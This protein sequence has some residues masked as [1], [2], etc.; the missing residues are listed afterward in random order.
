MCVQLP[1]W[2][3]CVAMCRKMHGV[4]ANSCSI[5]LLKTLLINNPSSIHCSL[6]FW[7]L[8]YVTVILRST[9][10]FRLDP[11]CVCGVVR[12]RWYECVCPCWRLRFQIDQHGCG[13]STQTDRL[14][15]GRV[16]PS[17]ALCCGQEDDKR[18]VRAAT[19]LREGD[20]RVCGRWEK[21][22]WELLTPTSCQSG[23][24]VQEA[25]STCFSS[26]CVFVLTDI[27]GNKVLENIATQDQKEQIKAYR[28]KLAVIKEVLARRHMKVAF[29]GRLVYLLTRFIFI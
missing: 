21:F 28:D 8:S 3:P 26:C 19:P 14:G 9:E 6:I 4:I 15:P 13:A 27:S 17:Q 29:F 11:N 12:A 23:V 25:H 5:T 7:Y 20:F 2:T 16:F 24:L 1:I 18:C 10:V 22:A